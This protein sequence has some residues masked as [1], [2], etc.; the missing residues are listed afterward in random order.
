MSRI[1]TEAQTVIA[2]LGKG[3][4][5][6]EDTIRA[7]LKLTSFSVKNPRSRHPVDKPIK[8]FSPNAV[9]EDE[10]VALYAFLNR[11]WFERAWIVQEISLAERLFV[12]CGS[13]GFLWDCL[14]VSLSFLKDTGLDKKLDELGLWALCPGPALK[15]TRT[16]QES[17]MLVFPLPMDKPAHQEGAPHASLETR[18][19]FVAG[20]Q[21]A[22]RALRTI[23][24]ASVREKA[25]SSEP[26]NKEPVREKMDE[27]LDF[28][29]IDAKQVY[30]PAPLPSMTSL[31]RKSRF[32]DASDPRDKVYAFLSLESPDDP[33]S[34]KPVELMSPD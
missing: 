20:I 29:V 15:S 14:P 32:C 13:F 16:M 1:F 23:V 2:W 31:L 27:Q 12:M 7:L 21:D 11:T 25:S 6:Y 34:N 24:E 28:L 30:Q 26:P 18:F 3:D 9:T 5:F 4:V 10:W 19:V 33:P 22:R 17:G 8:V